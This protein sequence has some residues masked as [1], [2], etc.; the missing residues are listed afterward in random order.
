[1]SIFP[2]VNI[3]NEETQKVLPNTIGRTFLF[4]SQTGQLIF[5]DGKPVEVDYKQA[6]EQ[7]IALFLRTEL[8]KYNVYKST[9]FGMQ[10]L[11]NLKGHNI[12]ANNY[13]QAEIK[14]E[15]TE[16]LEQCRFIKK[17][18]NIQLDFSNNKL[19]INLTAVLEDGEVI[20]NEVVL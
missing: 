1:M 20:V 8:N 7:W 6:A 9:N 11:Y 5:K 4:N 3:Y 14:R 12:V 13:M 10:D 17:V 18:Q 19:V 2:N 16:K 15:V